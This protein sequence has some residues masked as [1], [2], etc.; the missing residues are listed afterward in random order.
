MVKQRSN[1]SG[2]DVRY[3]VDLGICLH[4]DLPVAV[5]VEAVAGRQSALI[6]LE[7]PPFVCDGAQPVEQADCR[8]IEVDEDEL[9]EGFAADPCQAAAAEIEVSKI[10]RI[11]DRLQ[12]T[13]KRIAPAMAFAGQPEP[14]AVGF[15]D[16]R[17]AAMRAN[18]IKR[19]HLSLFSVD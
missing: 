4:G 9:A 2:V 10:F 3:V 7:L 11:F 16:D 13:I 8:I 19:F 14:L 17:C 1:G 18:V 6:E 5:E 15:G 12:F